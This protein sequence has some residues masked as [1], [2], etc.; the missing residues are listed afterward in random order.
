MQPT[1]KQLNALEQVLDALD[2]SQKE[3]HKVFIELSLTT[4][5]III[6]DA[7]WREF[8]FFKLGMVYATAKSKY[9]FVP[10]IVEAKK[11]TGAEQ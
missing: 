8:R 9:E 7:N 11:I 10:P 5:K 4:E 6:K 3:A 2:F 1:E